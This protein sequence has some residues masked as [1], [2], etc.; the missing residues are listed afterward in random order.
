MIAALKI[1]CV[2]PVPPVRNIRARSI[3]GSGRPPAPA[4]TNGAEDIVVNVVLVVLIADSTIPT[5]STAT[6]P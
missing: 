2:L 6:S 1:A 5:P 3:A 4:I